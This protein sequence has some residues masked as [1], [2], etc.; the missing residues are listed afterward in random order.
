MTIPRRRFL[1]LAAGAAALPALP[2]A[3]V[4]QSYPSRPVRMIVGFP[5]GSAPDIM[6]RLV[7]QWLGDKLGQQLI[8]DNRPGVASNIATEYAVAQPGDGYTVQMIVL[9]N[10]MNAALYSKLK[11]K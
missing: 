2:R 11:F 4:A 10:V 7:G 8:I 9:T 1:H 6:A 5:P 3:A